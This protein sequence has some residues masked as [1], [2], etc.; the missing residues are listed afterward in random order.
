MVEQNSELRILNS[1]HCPTKQSLQ[2][3]RN[4]FVDGLIQEVQLS[5]QCSDFVSPLGF[6]M[7]LVFHVDSGL[8]NLCLLT[9]AYMGVSW[10]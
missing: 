9:R 1:F 7:D 4:W 3:A 2:V 10:F 5:G 6:A 8:I